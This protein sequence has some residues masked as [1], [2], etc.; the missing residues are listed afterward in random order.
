MPR[1]GTEMTGAD[2]ETLLTCGSTVM[3]WYQHF[4]LANS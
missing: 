2:N 4:C 1:Y 3:A